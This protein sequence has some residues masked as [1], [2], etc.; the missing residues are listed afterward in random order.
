MSLISKKT[1]RSFACG[2]TPP[3][4]MFVRNKE[5][6]FEAEITFVCIM[7]ILLVACGGTPQ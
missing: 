4:A 5:I 6:V 1:Y 7:K 3:F 2:G